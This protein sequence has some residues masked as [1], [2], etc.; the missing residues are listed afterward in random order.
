MLQNLGNGASGSVTFCLDRKTRQKFAIKYFAN[1]EEY[2]HELNM[3][4]YLEDRFGKKLSQMAAMVDDFDNDSRNIFYE[5]GKCSLKE[6]HEARILDKKI[7]W[8]DDDKQ[9]ELVYLFH[10][11]YEILKELFKFDIYHSD[12]KEQN[13]ILYKEQTNNVFRNYECKLIDFGATVDSYEK[14]IACT[15]PYFP[16]Y[17]YERVGGAGP[18][19]ESR[20]ERQ[21]AEMY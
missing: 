21:Q 5:C 20:A 12:I 18:V 13:V 6:F 2:E 17:I 4:K 8:Q 10:R 3:M 19:F 11:I 15:R 1:F 7:L 9:K 16:A 14:F